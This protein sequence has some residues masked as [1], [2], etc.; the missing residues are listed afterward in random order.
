MS[1]IKEKIERLVSLFRPEVE[2]SPSAGY[3]GFFLKKGRIASLVL[4]DFVADGCL[5]R[6]SALTFTSLL[7]IVPLL[8]LMFALLKGFGVQN[9][10]EPI[11]LDNL[12]MGSEAVVAEILLY[13]ENTNV[14]RLGVVGLLTLFVTV[15][16]MLSNIEKSFNAVWGVEETRS[17]YRR[18]ADYFSVVMIGPVFIFA[19]ISMT[20]TLQSNAVVHALKEKALVGDLMLFLFKILPFV[21]MWIAFTALYMFMPNARVSKRAALIGG[22]FGGTL[23]QLAQWGY[24]HFQV[25][26]SKYNAI[27]GTMAALPIFMMWIYLSWVIVLLGLELTYA[28]QHLRRVSQ[29]VRV[30]EVN[31]ASREMLALG[32]FLM[33]AEAFY[34]GGRP[35]TLDDISVALQLPPRLA[36]SILG[37]LVRLGALSEVRSDEASDYAY[38]PAR[39][40]QTLSVHDFLEKIRWDGVDVRG[41]RQ[42]RVRE[43]VR[44]IDQRLVQ[45]RREALAGMSLH[46]LA[47]RVM[48]EEKGARADEEDPR[49]VSR[50]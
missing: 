26:V 29:E 33:L 28:V 4:H 38:Q 43:L 7:A 24:V 45:A 5:L 8:A 35:R 2:V 36:R 34:R 11:I 10:L 49:S 18:F 16:A 47:M 13:I 1:G 27:Y 41:A 9:Q 23:W 39:T 6:A 37:Q 48:A 17:L 50:S 30:S 3:R 22:I 32:V 12:A 25:G 46:E 20:S 14:G 15:L 40:L 31:F 21:G 44:D 19:A 42:G